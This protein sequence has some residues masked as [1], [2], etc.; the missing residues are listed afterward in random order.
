M[1]VVALRCSRNR[2][3]QAGGAYRQSNRITQLH[4]VCRR[5]NLWDEH[6]C[7]CCA[8]LLPSRCPVA[9]S[10][11]LY[12]TQQL[13]LSVWDEALSPCIPRQEAAVGRLRFNLE[14]RG[15]SVTVVGLLPSWWYCTLLHVASPANCRAHA[16]SDSCLARLSS[17][18]GEAVKGICRSRAVA[19]LLLR[20][21][22]HPR[23]PAEAGPSV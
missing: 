2:R 20:L 18:E 23:C 10:M 7:L 22:P 14:S 11:A 5:P 4:K 13:L 9:N 12:A 15:E 16:F 1:A 6:C 8:A 3:L 21:F 17:S 19:V